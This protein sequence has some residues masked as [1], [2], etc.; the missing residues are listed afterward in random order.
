MDQISTFWICTIVGAGGYALICGGFG[1]YVADMKGRSKLEGLLFGF[2]LGP[3][4]VVA[5]ACLPDLRKFKLDENVANQARVIRDTVEGDED[6]KVRAALAQMESKLRRVVER[7]RR[8]PAAQEL[9][10]GSAPSAPQPR[11]PDSWTAP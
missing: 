5:A 1:A 9:L 4:G 11:L 8:L 6:D 3:I 7:D 2:F 10:G